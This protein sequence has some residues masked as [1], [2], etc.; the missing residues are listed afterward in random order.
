[1]GWFKTAMLKLF[2]KKIVENNIEKYG[3]SKTKLTAAIYVII[4]AVEV[5]SP[6]WGH[7][8]VVSPEIKQFLAGVGLW[9]LRD[10]IKNSTKE[11]V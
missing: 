5:L 4:T 7:P 2:G 11:S 3:L 1:M 10:S 9:T 6:Q 8:I